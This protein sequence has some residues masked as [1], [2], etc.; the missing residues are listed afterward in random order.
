MS[1]RAMLRMPL[2][3]LLAAMAVFGLVPAAGAVPPPAEPGFEASS[4]P[5]S[6]DAHAPIFEDG[7]GWPWGDENALRPAFGAEDDEP[8]KA[9][10]VAPYFSDGGAAEPF[11]VAGLDPRPRAPAFLIP[12]ETGPPVSSLP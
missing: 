4:I 2:I 11:S 1:L 8:A 7:E 9:I 10:A 6:P 12:Y 3:G 5:A